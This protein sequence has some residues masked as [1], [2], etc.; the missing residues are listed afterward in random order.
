LIGL[1][2]SQGAPG[3]GFAGSQGITGFYGSRGYTGSGANVAAPVGAVIWMSKTGVLTGNSNLV[4]DGLN[5]TIGGDFTFQAAS[6]SRLKTNI[7]VID[8]AL[9]KVSTLDG[10]TFNWNELAVSKDQTI[11]VPG[12]IAQQVQQVL[13]E[14]VKV[15]PDG[16]L[17][18]N[19]DTLIPLLIEAIKEL[20]K[21]VAALKSRELPLP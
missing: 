4:F 19:Y 8:N 16:Y 13:P 12:I 9:E 1:T 7:E 14:A 5:L 11:R 21:E 6:D 10:V 2:G 15:R 20:N 18:V 3:A 17:G